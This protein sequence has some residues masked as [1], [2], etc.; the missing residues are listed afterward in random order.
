MAQSEA[1]ID[2]INALSINKDTPE[3]T[4]TTNDSKPTL[5]S[6]LSIYPIFDN[7]CTHLDI[8]GLLTLQRISK[9]LASNLAVHKKARWN[10]NNRLKR[11]VKDPV[12]LRSLMGQH[13]ALISGSF[14]LELL[15]G[16]SWKEPELDIYMQY[17]IS[18]KAFRQYL[19]EEGYHCLGSNKVEAAENPNQHPQYGR[20]GV[21]KASISMLLLFRTMADN[22]L[23]C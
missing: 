16:V 13:D 14:V 18:R 1:L 11:F 2:G 12:K 6:V 3:P 20:E 9:Q 7:L 10:V 19:H 15:A 23:D 21:V 22:L 8:A 5:L 17:S 4:V